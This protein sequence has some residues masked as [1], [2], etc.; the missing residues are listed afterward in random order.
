M[1]V[2][3]VVTL[4]PTEVSVHSIDRLKPT[5]SHVQLG[6]H[7]ADHFQSFPSGLEALALA[8]F[9]IGLSWLWSRAHVAIRIHPRKVNTVDANKCDCVDR[10]A[11]DRC[12]HKR[13]PFLARSDKIHDLSSRPEA[14]ARA[15]VPETSRHIKLTCRKQWCI[16]GPF[17][18]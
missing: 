18:L 7:V 14:L 3:P 9:R 4:D 10:K 13:S 16:K 17:W 6:S 5:I 8:R 12:F 1:N 15:L 11:H 2:L